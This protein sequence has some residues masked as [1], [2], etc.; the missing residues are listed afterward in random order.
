MEQP[1]AGLPV[2]QGEDTDGLR[3][4]GPGGH[5]PLPRHLLHVQPPLLDILPDRRQHAR[6]QPVLNTLQC[7]VPVSERDHMTKLLKLFNQLL[8]TLGIREDNASKIVT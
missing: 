1:P 5:V 2:R 8:I 7:I 3:E 4:G 6:L